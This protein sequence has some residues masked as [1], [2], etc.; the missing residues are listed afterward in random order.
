MMESIFKK[1]EIWEMDGGRITNVN[2]KSLDTANE[3]FE[4]F[5]SLYDTFY[6]TIREDDN[7][8]SIHT[9]GWSE[10]EYLINLFNKTSWW[11]KYHEITAKGGHYFFNTD[12]SVDKEWNVISVN[13]G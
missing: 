5:K 12:T 9:G 1:Y 7:L 3:A 6:G 4:L 2:S 11:W 10:N 13:N 8:I